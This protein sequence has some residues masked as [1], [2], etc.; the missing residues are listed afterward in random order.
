[1]SRDKLK[2][3]LS[4]RNWMEWIGQAT[5]FSLGAYMLGCG[6]QESGTIDQGN[7]GAGGGAGG[8]GA[9]G[10]SGGA[11]G[12]AGNAPADAGLDA[13]DV[14]TGPT[15]PCED[16]KT[17]PFDFQPPP[18]T[19]DPFDTW[20][21]RTVDQQ[22]LSEILAS[23]KLR[24][25]GMVESPVELSFYE[26]LCLAR[27]DQVVDFHCVEGW[28]IYDVPWNGVHL[29]ALLALAKPL[30]SATHV[31]F[32]TIGSKYNESLPLDV[33]LEPKTL[34]AYGVNGSSLPLARGFPARL[35]VPRLF[36]Y[37]SAKYVER[38]ELTDEPVEGFWVAA[39]YGYDAEVPPDRLRPGKY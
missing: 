24:V 26:M 37:K 23:W 17:P 38:I 25:D 11:A 28:S 8:S 29:S 20:P 14:E 19:G 6:D 34:L 3:D 21:V 5:V 9:A 12:S 27:R 2:G 4:R 35:V 32:H 13:V 30:S 18:N 1:M 10:G 16:G 15:P 33:A 22:T 31:T 7:A 36:G 39:G